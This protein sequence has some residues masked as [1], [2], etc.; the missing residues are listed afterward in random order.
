MS[1]F[2]KMWILCRVLVS[3]VLAFISVVQTTKIFSMRH[4]SV[5]AKPNKT[6]LSNQIHPIKMTEVPIAPTFQIA[7][8]CKDNNINNNFSPKKVLTYS[9]LGK[10]YHSGSSVISVGKVTNPDLNTSTLAAV[11]CLQRTRLWAL[12][13]PV[14]IPPSWWPLGMAFQQFPMLDNPYYKEGLWCP[15]PPT[16]IWMLHCVFVDNGSIHPGAVGGLST[17]QHIISHDS[18]L[19]SAIP[20]SKKVHTLAVPGM[21]YYPEAHGHFPNEILPRLLALHDRVPIEVPLLW[22]D[23][24][25]S[26]N[27]LNEMQLVGGFANRSIYFHDLAD[28]VLCIETAYVYVFADDR[29]YRNN[30][31]AAASDELRDVRALFRSTAPQGGSADRLGKGRKDRP[32]RAA[33]ASGGG[34]ELESI[35]SMEDRSA[36]PITFPIIIKIIYYYY[37]YYYY[38]Y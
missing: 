32:Q 13:A 2:I 6:A 25:L 35:E 9:Q 28:G 8:V 36:G 19:N 21:Y 14:L 26:R 27:L 30:Y 23:T 4:F 22:P 11:G 34:E 31:A 3:C 20:A 17:E 29:A 10:Y 12:K 18:R 7:S 33:A 24:K 5:M 16:E 1:F 15:P 38:Y 37:Y